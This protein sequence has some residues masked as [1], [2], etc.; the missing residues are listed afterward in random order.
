MGSYLG[1]SL[2]L[3]TGQWGKARRRRQEHDVSRGWVVRR[4][5]REDVVVPDARPLPPRYTLQGARHRKH[6][7]GKMKE[8]TY[9]H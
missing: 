2:G 9:E 1:G 7:R 4:R 5:Q 6:E 8:G 3:H